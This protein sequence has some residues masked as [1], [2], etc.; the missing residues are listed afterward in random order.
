VRVLFETYPWAFV[1]PG[2]GERQLVE[3]AKHLPAH[4]VDVVL[5]DHWNP[6]LETVDAVHFFSCIGGSLHFCNFVR[7]RGLPLVITSSLWIEEETKHLYPIDE[8][9]SQLSLADVVVTNSRA[10]SAALSKVLGLPADLFMPVM[11]GVDSRFAAPHDAIPFRKTFGID[12]PFILN[13]ANIERRKN[14]LNLVLALSHQDL[15]LVMIGQVREPAYAEQV[16]AEGE[17]KVR[18]LGYLDHE[19]PLLASA[20]AACAA[21][22]L[23]STLE[24][25]G[26]AALEA[27][28]AG[29]Q[30]VV[31]R[32]GAPPEYFGVLCHYVDPEDPTNI[33]CGIAAA[34]E[35]GPL[36][37]LSAHVVKNFTW[38]H[39]TAAL[40]GVY[41]TA[42][43]RRDRRRG[44]A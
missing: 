29:A 24:T 14:Q 5:H 15:P 44:A 30:V 20:Y 41:R 42:M 36:P 40:P 10:E 38:P 12:G 28:A 34:L 13:V 1:T 6:V 2:G 23:P 7:A 11:N 26:L 8:I 21:F 3:Y 35:R 18:Y 9:R 4:G 43:A 31:T 32:V 19:S 17:G 16:F 33:A 22:V 39:V 25:P 37:D 27:A